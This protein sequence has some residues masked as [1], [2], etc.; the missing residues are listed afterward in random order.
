[1]VQ[2]STKGRLTA[3]TLLQEVGTKAGPKPKRTKRRLTRIK[4][5]AAGHKMGKHQSPHPIHTTNVGSSGRDPENFIATPGSQ[6]LDEIKEERL[7]KK[8]RAA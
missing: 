1:M 3:A 5:S 4:K 7:K 2:K 6:F 8:R